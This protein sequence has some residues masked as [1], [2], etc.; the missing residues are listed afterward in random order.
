MVYVELKSGAQSGDIYVR[1]TDGQG[2]PT[3][4]TNGGYNTSPAWSCDGARIVFASDDTSQGT[5]DLFTIKPDGTGRTNL[6][7]T[8]WDE[9]DPEYSPD[10]TKVAY[11]STQHGDWDVMVMKANGSDAGDPLHLTTSSADEIIPSWSPDGTR[12]AFTSNRSG[13]PQ[14]F[15][16]PTTTPDSETKLLDSGQVTGLDWGQSLPATYVYTMKPDGSDPQKVTLPITGGMPAWSPDATRIA[17]TDAGRIF[18]IQPDGRGLAQLTAAATGTARDEEPSY[19][20]DGTKVAF[21]G[22]TPRAA[23]A[24]TRSTSTVAPD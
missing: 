22:T 13:K 17:F 23:R 8:A 3:R 4:L 19:S 16:M 14:I 18:T 20:P 10:G 2:T 9:S 6:T 15:T 1:N 11:T 21:T 12:L 7:K 24:S 5:T